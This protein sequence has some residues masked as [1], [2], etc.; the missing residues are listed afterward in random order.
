MCTEIKLDQNESRMNCPDVALVY[1]TVNLLID[2]RKLLLSRVRSY[3]IETDIPVLHALFVISKCLPT[4]THKMWILFSRL[5]ID[6][7]CLQHSK[8]AFIP[9][10]RDI[11]LVHQV[12]HR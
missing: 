10:H 8:Q 9:I 7:L 2:F 4:S 11:A 5:S 1:W 12:E 6:Y 3:P